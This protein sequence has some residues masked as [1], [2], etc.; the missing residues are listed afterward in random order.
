M[1]NMRLTDS[2]INDIKVL[3]S[4]I[5]DSGS[6]IE[7]SNVHGLKIQKVM[8][9]NNNIISSY[10]TSGSVFHISKSDGI[11]IKDGNFTNNQAT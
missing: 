1:Y 2:Y 6:A 7:I 9:E 4:Q 11:E 5:N 10:E 8:A 3:N